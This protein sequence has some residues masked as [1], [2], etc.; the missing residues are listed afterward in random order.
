MAMIKFR[1]STHS[2][3]SE[4]VAQL[5]PSAQDHL[6]TIHLNKCQG[7]IHHLL[8]APT[9][10]NILAIHTTSILYMCPNRSHSLIHSTYQLFLLQ[11]F[12]EDGD[13]SQLS[14]W[15]LSIR[16]NH[17]KLPKHFTSSSFIFLLSAL[18]I[19]HTLGL[20]LINTTSTIAP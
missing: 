16:V 15:P 1:F 13:H 18:P 5:P 14:Q 10:N 8:L 20:Y 6:H 17:I 19:G 2:Y 11:H 4:T 12:Y 3:P 7:T 9:I